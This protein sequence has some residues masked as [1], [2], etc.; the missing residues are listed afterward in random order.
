MGD[1]NLKNGAVQLY[2]VEQWKCLKWYV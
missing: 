2:E 1:A